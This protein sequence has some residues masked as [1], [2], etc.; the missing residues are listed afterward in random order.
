MS[1]VGL[2][3]DCL[4]KKTHLSDKTRFFTHRMNE[5]DNRFI[6]DAIFY[7]E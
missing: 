7:E 3:A 6:P 2:M 1:V 5:Y 4:L